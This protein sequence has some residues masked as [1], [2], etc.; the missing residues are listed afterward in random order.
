MI[1]LKERSKEVKG[2][3]EKTMG[4][5]NTGIDHGK[6]DGRIREDKDERAERAQVKGEG[7]GSVRGTSGEKRK[8]R[9]GQLKEPK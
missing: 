7:V 2:D 4:Q 5:R 3:T 9:S 6:G 1:N 8:E